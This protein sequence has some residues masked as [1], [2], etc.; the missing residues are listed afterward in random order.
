MTGTPE[1]KLPDADPGDTVSEPPVAHGSIILE[2]VN[3]PH[4]GHTY[5]LTNTGAV[6]RMFYGSP[7]RPFYRI[8]PL[9]VAEHVASVRAAAHQRVTVD[10]WRGPVPTVETPAWVG[11]EKGGTVTETKAAPKEKAKPKEKAA[12]KSNGK[13]PKLGANARRLLEGGLDLNKTRQKEVLTAANALAVARNDSITRI[14]DVYEA[15][16]A[17]LPDRIKETKAE[18]LKTG[19]MPKKASAGNGGQ[20]NS[21]SGESQKS[22][23]PPPSTTPSG[24]AESTR[25]ASGESV[26]E[27]GTEAPD[28]AGDETL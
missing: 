11:G 14:W 13:A 16:G 3:V 10:R 28:P 25:T 7:W 5:A 19:R 6:F 22:P 8:E 2:Y 18:F 12:P 15:A 23:D 20:G 17:P 24:S 4:D 26:L 1:P 21:S 27:T 9:A